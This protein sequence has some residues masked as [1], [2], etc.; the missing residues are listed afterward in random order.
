MS[1]R[2]IDLDLYLDG[3]LLVHQRV[4]SDH[5]YSLL[6]RIM[7]AVR[8]P[9]LLLL[10]S[11]DQE[12]SCRNTNLGTRHSLHLY[13]NH[14]QLNKNNH[15]HLLRCRFVGI[16]VSTHHNYPNVLY[17]LKEDNLLRPF[18]DPLLQDLPHLYRLQDL[19]TTS[20]NSGS[21]HITA[22]E[23]EKSVT[24]SHL[25]SKSPSESKKT[26]LRQ[27]NAANTDQSENPKLIRNSDIQSSSSYPYNNRI[28]MMS[29]RLSSPAAMT[30]SLDLTDNITKSRTSSPSSSNPLRP[31]SPVVRI[32]NNCTPYKP[33][34]RSISDGSKL[35]ILS[36]A[37]LQSQ[38]PPCKL[39]F[40]SSSS[41]PI[42]PC[43]SRPRPSTPSSVRSYIVDT[44]RKGK[45]N[46]IHID[47]IHRL[48]L[49]YNQYLQWR[50][51]NA[52]S[53]ATMLIKKIT[54]EVT[55]HFK[56]LLMLIFILMLI[57][58]IY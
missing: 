34:S 20:F 51:V 23:K 28:S 30:R 37:S 25:A 11:F 14:L 15:D 10:A 9:L 49:L 26:P 32:P 40:P 2:L 53:E 27:R 8:L 29:S 50:I 48:R 12:K 21:T 6:R 35:S 3:R 24:S 56:I 58:Q 47:N 4:A 18:L 22:Y 1:A 41:R 54:A 43:S 33:L 57:F 46:S 36:K 44:P 55:F 13:P 52:R 42:T 39:P 5:H 16:P 17:Q 45:K 38:L 7:A 31:R 19:L